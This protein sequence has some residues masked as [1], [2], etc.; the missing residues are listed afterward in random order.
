MGKPRGIRAGRKLNK[1]RKINRWADNDWKQAHLLGKWKSD[2]LGRASHAK[3]IVLEKVY[4]DF[5]AHSCFFT[6]FSSL[7]LI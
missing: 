2:P 6:S 3:G 4:V 5:I 7:H 1:I